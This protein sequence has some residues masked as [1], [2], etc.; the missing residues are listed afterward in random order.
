VLN[1]GG[2][3]VQYTGFG[4][5]SELERILPFHLRVAAL[6]REGVDIRV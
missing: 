4:A 1:Q 5:Q 2:V 6:L 3:R